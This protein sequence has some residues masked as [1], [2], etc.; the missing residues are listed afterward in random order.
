MNAL[1]TFGGIWNSV[2]AWLLPPLEDEI[3]ELDDK[4]RQFVAVCEICALQEHMADYRW[5]GNGCPPKDRLA[6]CKAFIAKAV[7]NFQTTRDLRDEIRHRPILR[8]LCGWETLGMVPSESTFSRSFGDFA[9][10]T[11]PQRIHQAMI[12]ARYGDKIAGHVNRDSTAIDAREKAAGKKPEKPKP[13]GKRGRRPADEPPAIPEP[14]RLQR[15]LERTLEQN[16]ADLPCTCD[17]ASKRNSKGKVEHW[18]GY[19]AH[20]DVIDGDIP[21]SFILLHLHDEHGGRHVRVRGAIKVA[22]HLAFGLVVIAAEQM[23]KLLG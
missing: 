18:R 20:L 14:T 9:H 2:Q 17:W 1:A 6:L 15:Q 8:R 22:A 13:S 21:V 5:V 19:K 10:D 12:E 7:W 16:L 23:L 4:H 3:G 11:L